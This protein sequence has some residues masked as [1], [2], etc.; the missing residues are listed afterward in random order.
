MTDRKTS[1][2]TGRIELVGISGGEDRPTLAVHALSARSKVLGTAR[3]GDDGSFSL[4]ASAMEGAA[5]IVIADASADPTS[6]QAKVVSYRVDEARALLSSDALPISKAIWGGL[7]WRFQCVSGSVRRC[8]PWRPFFDELIASTQL[9]AVRLAESVA[10]SSKLFDAAVIDPLLI[11]LPY[12]CA[13]VCQGTVEV[14]RRTC[15]CQPPI[16]I[17]P[18]DIVEG[19][20]DWPPPP[21]SDPPFIPP[22]DVTLPPIPPGPGPD[23][24]P[25]ELLERVSTGGALDARKLNARRDAVALQAL[26]GP[27]LSDYLSIRPYLWCTC[28]AGTKVAQGLV[29]DDGTFSICW[30]EF[31]RFL[32]PNC[33]DE[34]A[35]KVTQI[36]N[37][38][39]VTIYDG[40]AAGQW[41]QAGANP[42]LT[43]YSRA[44]VACRNDPPIP[45]AGPHTVLLHDI[46][47]T[48]SWHLGTPAQDSPDS[49]AVPASN[50][51]LID[52]SATDG[53]SVN[54]PLG[55]ALGLRYAFQDMQGIAM[56]FR[57]DVAPANTAG[58][59]AGAWSPVAVPAWTYWKIVGNTIVRDALSLSAG[60]GLF[61]IPYDGVAPLTNPLEQWDDAQFH[62]VLDTGAIPNGKY[63]VRIQ[64]FNAARAQIK[65]VGAS[66][67]GNATGFKFGRWRLQAGPPDDVPYSALTHLVWSNNQRAQ[68]RVEGVRLASATGSS[69][70]QFLDGPSGAAVSIDYRAYHEFAPGAGEPSFLQGWSLGVEKGING[71]TPLTAS[72]FPEQG[73]PPGA[74]ASNSSSTLGSLLGTDPKCAFAVTVYAAVKTTDG[75]GRLQS[76]DGSTVAAFAAEQH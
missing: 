37:G 2:L 76:L 7:F 10:G 50:S 73:K 61:F 52:P 23:P 5:R 69:T 38:V 51:G 63:L 49:V 34:Y 14:Y 30:R 28:G 18:G 44:A 26:R 42:T 19:P 64:V 29:A 32:V 35:Y 59:P 12:R 62:G 24:A 65:P 45:G 17:D 13:P 25:L 8:Y 33:A 41:F 67:T 40:P 46:G 1:A 20:I 39:V 3:L 31:P 47:S 21:P 4:P 11:P 27:Q 72:G 68:A 71:G 53:P 15:C 55:G 58:D 22:G 60:G 16:W 74:A 66:G 57:V 36:I 75:S 9:S 56:F 70:C 48:E 43:S 6:E 54:R